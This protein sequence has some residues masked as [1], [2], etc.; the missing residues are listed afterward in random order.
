MGSGA[1]GQKLQRLPSLEHMHVSNS[2]V[3]N[4]FRER[5]VPLYEEVQRAANEVQTHVLNVVDNCQHEMEVLREQVAELRSWKMAFE[6]EGRPLPTSKMV[7]SR[8]NGAEDVA[9]LRADFDDSFG[10]EVTKLRER[11]TEE[12]AALR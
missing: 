10:A 8:P 6:L 7:D 3:I 5:A 9:A 2:D 1:L 12:V 11:M 4:V